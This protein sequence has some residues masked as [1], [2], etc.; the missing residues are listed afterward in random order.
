MLIAKKYKVIESSTIVKNCL[1]STKVY[2]DDFI[3]MNIKFVL[4]FH[5]N[6]EIIEMYSCEK[7]VEKITAKQSTVTR[8]FVS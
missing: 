8:K 5:E 3:L 7:T 6:F 1:N 2:F 4:L